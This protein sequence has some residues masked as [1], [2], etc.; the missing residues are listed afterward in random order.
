E[1]QSYLSKLKKLMRL[2]SETEVAVIIGSFEESLLN[3]PFADVNIFGVSKELNTSF[4][5][6][7]SDKINTSVI[8]L[9]DSHQENAIV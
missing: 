9:K 4:M 1:A 6:E 8:F 2:S 7:I 3:A 5:R